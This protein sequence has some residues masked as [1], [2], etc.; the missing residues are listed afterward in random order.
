MISFDSA[1]EE[2]FQKR[3]WGEY[4]SEEVIRFVARNFYE[5][6]QAEVRLLD[7]GCGTGAVTW[8]M[9]REGFDVYAFDGSE[10]AVRKARQ[11]MRTEGVNAKITVSD[12]ASFPYPDTFF[13]GIVDSAML[14]ANRIDSITV[15]LRECFRTLK[16]GGKFFSTG[17]FNRNMTGYGTGERL[18]ENTYRDIAEGNLA[19]RGTVHFFAEAELSMLWTAA[20]FKNIS[21]DS[22]E[23]TADGGKSSTCYYMVESEKN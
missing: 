14:Y 23:R 5:K 11:R 2:L 13:D 1:W 10:T 9:A 17:L 22:L 3:D 20:G 21:I 4:P 19:G 7:M 15:I 8:F 18:E 12:A 16:A 6:N